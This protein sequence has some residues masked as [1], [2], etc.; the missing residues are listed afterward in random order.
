MDIAVRFSGEYLV[1][2]VGWDES[3]N[4]V[5]LISKECIRILLKT[6]RISVSS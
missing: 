1:A 6:Q 4:T 2:N 3:T 5:M